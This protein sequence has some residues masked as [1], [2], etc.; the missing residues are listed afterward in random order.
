M[1]EM[2]FTKLL[3]V[4]VN[5]KEASYHRF[6]KGFNVITGRDNHVG[7]S[8][9]LKSLFFALGAEVYYS[10]KWNKQSKMYVLQRKCLSGP[11]ISPLEVGWSKFLINYGVWNQP[12]RTMSREKSGQ[13]FYSCIDAWENSRAGKE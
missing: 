6:S 9:I 5:E 8:T 10:S 1:S 13:N 3:V 12:H 4:D 7:K 2:Y 11:C